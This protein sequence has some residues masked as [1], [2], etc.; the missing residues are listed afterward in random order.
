MTNIR[1]AL[2][3][4]REA[5]RELKESRDN[6]PPGYRDRALASI[7][8]A[9]E[10]L[11]TIL[12]VNSADDVTGVKRNPDYYKRYADFPRTRAALQ[13]LR[14]ARD[15]LRPAVANFR[16]KKERALDDIDVAIGDIVVLLRQ[17]RR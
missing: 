3:E 5:R 8:D 1:A 4:L 17:K 13:D 10:S 2:Y 11:R 16:G 12:G 6:W 7:N 14:Q 15:A 9:V